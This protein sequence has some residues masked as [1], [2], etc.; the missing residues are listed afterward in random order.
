MIRRFIQIY[1]TFIDVAK[2]SSFA[3]NRDIV[4]GCSVS[5]IR[6]NTDSKE[7]I[8]DFYD[9]DEYYKKKKNQ[10][11]KLLDLKDENE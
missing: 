4:A 6:L 3:F 10:L 2:I 7:L 5:I 9:K 1:D 8:F 11:L